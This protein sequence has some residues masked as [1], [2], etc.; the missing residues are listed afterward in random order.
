MPSL[1][2]DGSFLQRSFSG[3]KIW[4]GIAFCLTVSG[5]MIYN[6]LHQETFYEVEAKRGDYVWRDHNS[7]GK[8]DFHDPSEFK[9][10]IEGDF[11]KERISDAWK[12]VH[13][14]VNTFCWLMVAIL[15]VGL[16]DYFYIIRIR[17]LAE[18]DL[19]VKAG[20]NVIMLWEFASALSPGVIGGTGV[21]MFIL[22]K[23]KIALGRATAFV[24][25]T[26]LLDNL[27]F[28]LLIPSV[29]LFIDVSRL[30]PESM[31]ANEG[32]YYLFWGGYSFF[33]LLSIL[34]VLTLFKYPRTG[35]KC[36]FFLSSRSWLHRWKGSLRQAGVDLQ[37]SA[38]IIKKHSWVFWLKTFGATIVSW[39]SRYIVINAILHAFLD[40]SFSKDLLI[41]GK[42]AVLWLLMRVSPTPGGSGVAEYAFS[43]LLNDLGYSTLLIAVLALLWRLLAYFPYLIIG[44]IL[45]P[46]WL[47][48]QKPV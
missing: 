17:L 40:I 35:K 39:L 15:F 23:E 24:L 34:L 33:L 16:R 4:I 13:W 29:F 42:Q 18:G 9:A 5:W 30:I 37:T 44:S 26:A 22:A 31:L 7:N 19:S 11:K 28:V 12:N 48:K 36:L 47:S 38:E 3:W 2:N 46:K 14:S 8:V 32:I 20:F 1:Q 10:S 45:L 21:A 41:V 25:V 6:S 27:F 43:S